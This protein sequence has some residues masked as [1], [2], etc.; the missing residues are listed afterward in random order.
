VGAGKADGEGVFG[1]GC[2]S[3]GWVCQLIGCHLTTVHSFY[4]FF[5]PLLFVPLQFVVADALFQ[6]ICYPEC[7]Y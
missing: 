7:M 4:C 2:L 1:D 5:Q 3:E 6:F